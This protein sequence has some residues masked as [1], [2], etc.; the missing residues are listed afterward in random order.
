[1]SKF[2]LTL[3]ASQLKT[4]LTCPLLWHYQYR[5]NLRLVDT[6]TGLPLRSNAADKG[7]LMH[8]LLETFYILRAENLNEDRKTLAN[9]TV[10]KFWDTRL[11]EEFNLTPE[12]GDFICQRFFHYIFK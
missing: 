2:T 6:F 12:V 5:E 4:Y 8:K 7:T 11:I 10:E 9:K 1:M 3:D